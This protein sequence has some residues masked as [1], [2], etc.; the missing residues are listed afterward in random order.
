MGTN[1]GMMASA[2]AGVK[3]QSP[4]MDQRDR[5]VSEMS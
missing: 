1:G 3:R 2:F 4:M 5:Y